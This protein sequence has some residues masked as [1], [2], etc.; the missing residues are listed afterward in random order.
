[1][2]R[3]SRKIRKFLRRRAQD[4]LDDIESQS[5]YAVIIPDDPLESVTLNRDTTLFTI[6]KDSLASIISH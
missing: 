5:D 2:I 4:D 6:K 3:L 1:M